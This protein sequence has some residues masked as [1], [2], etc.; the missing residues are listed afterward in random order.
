MREICMLRARRR[1][2]ET[3]SRATLNGHEGG[4]PGYGLGKDL[5]GHRAS[6]RPYRDKVVV[7]LAEARKKAREA[8]LAA[9][10]SKSC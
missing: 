4:D 10:R 3:E 2:L 7:D 1:G 8:R 9:N 6:P 5:M